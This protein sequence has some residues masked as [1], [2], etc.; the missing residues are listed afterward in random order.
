LGL[1]LAL[2]RGLVELHGGS[3]EARSA[4]PGGGSEFLV[5]LPCDGAAAV[6]QASSQPQAP[7]VPGRRRVLVIEDHRDAAETLRRILSLRGYDAAVASDGPQGLIEVRRARPDVVICDIGLP[8]MDGF[9]VAA[10][11]RSDPLTADIRLI[12]LTGYGREEDVRRA[13]DAGFDDHIVKPAAP[14]DLIRKIEARS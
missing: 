1:G 11:L 2:V 14:D 5:H 10:A 7:T 12:A 13:R 6:R 3:V 4:G 9:T 8:G